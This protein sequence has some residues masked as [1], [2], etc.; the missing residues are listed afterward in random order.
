MLYAERC[1]PADGDRTLRLCADEYYLA[2]HRLAS[3]LADSLDRSEDAIAH[4]RR[5]VEVAP[6]V[7]ASYLRLARCYFCVFDYESEI[8]TLCRLLRVAW[9]PADVGMALYWMGYAFWMTDRKRAGMACYQ[10]CVQFDRGLSEA[11]TSE[12]AEFM[13]KEGLRPVA[14]SPEE[15]AEVFAAEGVELSLVA[16]N[17]LILTKAASAALEAGSYRLA[18]NLLGSASV[19]LRDDALTPV[20]ESF[21]EDER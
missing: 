5:C 1:L 8:D 16:E 13:R 18:Q 20:L 21:G 4:A 9:N 12:V 3:M 19:L 7:G 2:H 10:R 11:C 14:V 6:S 17:T 15:E